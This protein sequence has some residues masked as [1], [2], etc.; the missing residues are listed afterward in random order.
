MTEADGII[1][2]DKTTT[3]GDLPGFHTF[4]NF[5]HILTFLIFLPVS[6]PNVLLPRGF[7]GRAGLIK[8]CKTARN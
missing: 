2:T 7:F 4:I 5:P 3:L 6:A 1:N 8:R